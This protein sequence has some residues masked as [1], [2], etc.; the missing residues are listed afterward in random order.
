MTPELRP[1]P[2]PTGEPPPGRDGR[3]LELIQR[4]A[5]DL[6]HEI[7]NPLNAIVINLEVLR[8]RAADEDHSAVQERVA[9]LG[10]EVRRLHRLV[11][12]LLGLLRSTREEGEPTT[13]GEL[14]ETVVTLLAPS[15]SAERVLIRPASGDDDAVPAGSVS[16]LRFALLHL[17]EL[18]LRR[19]DGGELRTHVEADEVEVRVTVSFPCGQTAG[20]FTAGVQE[21]VVTAAE[22][23]AEDGGRVE[24]VAPDASGAAA[25]RVLVPRT[26]S[27]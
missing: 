14:L 18:A 10:D 21:G 20:A 19:T 27:P 13:I 25:L 1:V 15:A 12:S 16:D 9:V 26:G 6:A 3:R 17:L 7:R 8:R 24:V 23:I 11:D 22:L 5:D 4:I 2:R